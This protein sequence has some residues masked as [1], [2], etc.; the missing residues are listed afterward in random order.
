M[1]NKKESPNLESISIEKTIDELIVSLEKELPEGRIRLKKFIDFFK[2]KFPLEQNPER[3]GR[4]DAIT[5]ALMDVPL[6]LYGLNKNGSAIIELHGILERFV[7]R[8]TVYLIR[9]SLEEGILTRVF[10]RF[11]LPELVEILYNLKKMEKADVKFAKKL[12]RIRNG[13]AHKNPRIISNIVLSGKEISVLDIDTVM[14]K[15]DCVPLLINAI[16]FLVRLSAFT[17]K[18]KG[19]GD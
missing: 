14:T 11:T 13:L 15:F 5:W 3:R 19:S 17:K 16:D 1:M 10:E 2:K 9:G 8:E 18:D 7:L 4:A 12:T 6:I